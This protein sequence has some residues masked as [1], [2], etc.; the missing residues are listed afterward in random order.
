MAYIGCVAKIDLYLTDLGLARNFIENLLIYRNSTP[1]KAIPKA[2][3]HV[4][5]MS[6]FV[7]I[8]ANLY[9]L[10]KQP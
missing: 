4:L 1:E 6:K 7:Y 3:G 9:F 5:Q 8:S 2:A 10:P